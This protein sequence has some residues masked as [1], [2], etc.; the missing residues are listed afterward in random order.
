MAAEVLQ[1]HDPDSLEWKD[2]ADVIVVGF[3]AAGAAAALQARESGRDVLLVDRFEGGGATAYS[4]GILYAGNTRHQRAAG[5]DDP[6]SNMLA[7]LAQEVGDA[8]R[9]DTL[10]RFCDESGPNLEWLEQHGVPFDSS[11]FSGKSTYPPEDKY[12]YYSGN[13]KLERFA[14]HATPA[15]RGH[16]VFGKGW[17]GKDLFARLKRAVERAGVRRLDHA[18]AV[19]LVV[20][21]GQRVV[22][23][24]VAKLPAACATQHQALYRKVN[25]LMP[26]GFAKA[27][28]AIA[29]ADGLENVA[30]TP[31]RLRAKRGVILATGG[32]AYNLDLMRRHLPLY[33]DSAECLLRLGSAG[34]NGDGLALARAAGADLGKMNRIFAGRSIS[35]PFDLLRGIVVNQDGRRFVNEDAYN[36]TL[37]EAIANQPGTRAWLILDGATFWSALRKHLPSGDGNFMTFYLPSLLNIL[38]GG[39][40]RGATLDALAA[41]CGIDVRNLKQTVENY[42]ADAHAKRPDVLGKLADYAQ[43]IEGP[44]YWAIN[45]AMRNK[46]SFMLFFTL[47]GIRVDEET[48]E[49]IRADGSPIRGLYAA[50]R[51]AVGVCANTYACSGIS[52][53]DGVFSGRRAG[54]H[55]AAADSRSSSPESTP[56]PMPTATTSNS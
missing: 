2:T 46:F 5:Y 34:C 49:A 14:R 28:A 29:S 40:R 4:G 16:R 36:A 25:P 6:P 35:P 15:P 42:N 21:A 26:F 22:G 19:R 51:A 38:F 24:E 23:V 54:R 44:S 9:P 31:W 52:L 20:D 18:R 56:W 45:L 53:A 33:A 55:A 3:G 39:T 7:Y 30:G 48:G 50:G 43:P 41:K 12:L 8:V 37:G 11:L 1:T 32:F 13:E 47:G 27:N 10:R 17:T